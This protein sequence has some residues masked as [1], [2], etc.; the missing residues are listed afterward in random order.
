M[1][2]TLKLYLRQDS[3]RDTDLLAEV[4]VYLEN[5]TA[6]EKTDQIYFSGSLN[7]L[8]IYV[9]ERGVSLQGSLA[10]YYLSDNMQTLRRQDTEQAIKK[11]SDDLHLPI[12][13]AQ[14]SRVDFAHNFIMQYEPEVYYPYLGESQYFKRYI[15]PES[16]YYK[17]GNR[18][19]LFYDKPAEAKSKGYKIPEVWAS[20]NVLR[21]EI[22]YRRRLDKQLKEP[23]IR[24]STLYDE[25]FY[26][27]L[28]NIYVSD[29]KSIHK[30][31]EIN[32]DTANM[33]TPKDFWDQMALLMIDRI[34]Q[35]GAVDL[36]EELRAKDVLDKP[37]YYSRLKKQIRDKSQKYSAS[38]STPLIE[39]LE[40]KVSAL[41]RFYR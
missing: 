22:R 41:K 35:N 36:V 6:H 13:V 9:S 17:N 37:E 33:R 8:R 29:Y 34:G 18:T 31:S 2:D 25:Q 23:E 32:L 20:K 5:I 1:F 11:L 3:V 4:P 39:E 40:S 26:I 15:Q 16:L 30:H 12:D 28:I 27:K 7:N 38:D 21:Y 24:A 14:V 10:K 19:K